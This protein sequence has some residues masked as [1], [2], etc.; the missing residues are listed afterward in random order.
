[1]FHKQFGVITTSDKIHKS[2]DKTSRHLA[3]VKGEG[4][5]GTEGIPS[6]AVGKKIYLWEVFVVINL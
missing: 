6:I 4:E 1:M 2:I 5:R 3:K